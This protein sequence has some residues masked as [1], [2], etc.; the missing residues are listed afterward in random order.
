MDPIGGDQKLIQS[1][2]KEIQKLLGRLAW[3]GNQSDQYAH[4]VAERIAFVFPEDND[5]RSVAA[6]LAAY[7]RR[8]GKV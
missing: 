6:V 3:G 1:A 2:L 4:E 8:V 7:G 5:L